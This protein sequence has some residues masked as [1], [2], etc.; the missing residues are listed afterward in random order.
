MTWKPQKHIFLYIKLQQSILT[1]L[2]VDK[3]TAAIFIVQE[4]GL[5]GS[6]ALYSFTGHVK[7][8]NIYQSNIL[9]HKYISNILHADNAILHS[10][11]LSHILNYTYVISWYVTLHIISNAYH[12]C[13]RRLEPISQLQWVLTAKSIWHWCGQA[14]ASP[15]WYRSWTPGGPTATIPK[16]SHG[17]SRRSHHC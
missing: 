3:Y 11:S 12:Q 8:Y 6:E 16:D 2:M 4:L 7:Y 14:A 15:Y 17:Q 13:W 10:V 5:W 1:Q 9:Y